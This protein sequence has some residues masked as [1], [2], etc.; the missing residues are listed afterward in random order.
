M[1]IISVIMPVRNERA[2]LKRSLQAVLAQDYPP[3]LKEI[4]IVDGLSDDGMADVP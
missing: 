4:F 1:P 2:Y 3:G